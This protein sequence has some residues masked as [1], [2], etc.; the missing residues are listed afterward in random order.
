MTSSTSNKCVDTIVNQISEATVN[1]AVL[2]GVT[3]IYLISELSFLIWLFRYVYQQFSRKVRST[4]FT[5]TMSALLLATS[6]IAVFDASVV[7]RVLDRTALPDFIKGNS[8]LAQRIC[9]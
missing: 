2:R 7:L 1:T 3:A 6:S 4:W 8:N 9:I 5:K